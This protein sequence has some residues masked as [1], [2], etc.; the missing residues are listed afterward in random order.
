MITYLI[1]RPVATSITVLAFVALGLY[2]YIRLPV[3]LLPGISIPHIRLIT[4]YPGRSARHIEEAV[5]S[6]LRNLLMS[7]PD[8]RDMQTVSEAGRSVLE[9]DFQY[10][11]NMKMATLEIHERLE[12]SLDLLPAEISRPRVIPTRAEDLPTSYLAVT[13]PD[14]SS[15]GP[16]LAEDR[17]LDLGYLAAG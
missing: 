4:D 15:H 6:P 14:R 5:T 12:R 8:L 10:G 7:L 17:F 11:T 3:T 13:F 16:A 2:G 1:K 9:L